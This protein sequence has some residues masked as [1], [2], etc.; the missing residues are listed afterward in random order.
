LRLASDQ[1]WVALAGP[2]GAAELV[3]E[4]RRLAG[5]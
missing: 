4:V 5:R 2:L 1:P 3:T